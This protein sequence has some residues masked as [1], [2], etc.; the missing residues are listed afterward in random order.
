MQVIEHYEDDV[1]DV[2]RY[3]AVLWSWKW[4]LVLGVAL[5]A[6]AAFVTSRLQTPVYEAST[7]L[8]INQ[9]PDTKTS[10][11]TAILTSERLARTYA[12]MIS[13]RTI[14]EE[15]LD[16]SELN[17]ELKEFAEAVE[18]ELVR[19]TQLI[20][21]RVENTSPRLAAN[22]A[23]ALVEVFVEQNELLQAERYVVSKGSLQAM[24]DELDIQIDDT[25]ASIE[26]I[27][28]P[29]DSEQLSKLALLETRLAQYRNSQTA[30]LQS[31]EELS[32][33]EAQ[34]SSI[35]KQIDF[36]VPPDEPVR[37]RTLLNTALGGMVG[38]ML[39]LGAVFLIEYLD[40]TV[41]SPEHIEAA[42]ELPVLGAI[43]HIPTLEDGRP[44]VAVEPRSPISEAFRA[45]RTNIQFAAVDRP[46]QTLL[47]TSA[48]PSEGKTLI[49]INLSIVMAQGGKSTAILDA[50][51]R[52]PRVH[53]SL[54]LP[55]GV[56]LSDLFVQDVPTLDGA[57]HATQIDDLQ[58]IVSGEL[59]P[60]PAELLG[61]ERMGAILDLLKQQVEMVLIDSSP[62][63]VVTDP[64][65]LSAQA[66]GV[67]LVVQPG[68]TEIGAAVQ[69]VESLRRSGANL[70]GVVL[71]NIQPKRAGYYGAY[72]YHYD[73]RNDE[74]DNA[75]TD[76]DPASS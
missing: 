6:G 8:L 48:I 54:G 16:R 31:F 5:S 64:V 14:L 60:N 44:H 58:A 1:I 50:D 76:K 39:A 74:L 52:R 42:L 23:N 73:Y 55:R 12:Q 40:D 13:N 36:A 35:V 20:E 57:L 71:N 62:V 7:T 34:S 2:R 19:D 72:Q 29:E 11:Y 47:I 67:L 53:T 51:L 17:Y 10:D 28:T 45:L 15:T 46:I 32:L 9:A 59:P 25:E 75:D 26:D 61:S 49:A 70:V 68:V 43:A 18:V 21:V 56:G 63:T 33:T 37:P 22:L 38:G 30:L 65:V 41:K 27:G 24:L 66:D 69:A 3:A 4:L